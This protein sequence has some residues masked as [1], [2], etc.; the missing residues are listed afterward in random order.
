MSAKI[1]KK[2]EEF[3]SICDLIDQLHDN[4]RIDECG[5]VF[6]FEG[7]VR[8]REA[9]KK[10]NRL[11]LTTNDIQKT[12][13]Q[14]LELIREIEEKSQVMEISVV[15]YVGEFH[16]GETLFIVAVAGPHREEALKAMIE[17]IERTKFELDFK[18]EEYTDKGTNIIM[19]GG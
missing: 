18:K 14:L 16:T 8:G 15:H 3:F 10:I 12:E 1:L 6:S 19:S 4:P 13:T 17:V 11:K 2:G 7:I 9:G 5:A